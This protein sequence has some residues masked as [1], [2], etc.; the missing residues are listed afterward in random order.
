MAARSTLA[1]RLARARFL[2][3]LIPLG[4]ALLFLLG[5]VL[6]RPSW[7]WSG[8]ARQETSHVQ[9]RATPRQA[10]RGYLDAA[11]ASEWTRA[12]EFLD[13]GGRR[14]APGSAAA[15]TLAR[16][17]KEVLDQTIWIDLSRVSDAPEGTGSKDDGLDPELERVGM[18]RTPQGEVPILL[19]R[20]STGPGFEWRFSADT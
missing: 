11:R 13:L 8:A 1:T 20:T 12:A 2:A 9:V 17:L 15:G 19:A 3:R 18:V 14:A 4:F 5:L 10:L 16:Q 7:A 6:A